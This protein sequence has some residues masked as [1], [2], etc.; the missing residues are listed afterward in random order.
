MDELNHALSAERQARAAAEVERAK[1]RMNTA[2][3]TD[4][5][6][7]VLLFMSGVA[8]P[9]Q[10]STVLCQDGAQGASSSCITDKQSSLWRDRARS[11]AEQAS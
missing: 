11:L 4:K 10:V 6:L 8:H 5:N 9:A 2:V 7:T 3:H 1:C